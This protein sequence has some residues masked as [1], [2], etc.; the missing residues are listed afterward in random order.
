MVAEIK[1]SGG[2]DMTA[3]RLAEDGFPSSGP[4]AFTCHVA[5]RSDAPGQLVAICFHYLTYSARAGRTVYLEDLYIRDAGVPRTPAR[6]TPDGRAGRL[7][8]PPRLLSH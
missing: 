8:A 6:H 5:E 1:L 3:E 2:M 7:G 4:A